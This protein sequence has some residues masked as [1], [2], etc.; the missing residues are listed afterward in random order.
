MKF[1]WALEWDQSSG[2]LSFCKVGIIII[3]RNHLEIVVISVSAYLASSSSPSF[4]VKAFQFLHTWTQIAAFECI[5]CYDNQI[6]ALLRTNTKCIQ[7]KEL[8]G[9][10]TTAAKHEKALDVTSHT[11][12]TQ[13]LRKAKYSKK[14]ITVKDVLGGFALKSTS[15][16]NCAH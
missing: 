13:A 9:T 12:L 6:K 14:D 8:F 11:F 7:V 4:C 15:S 1:D 2:A 5:Q 16:S 3:T 10:T